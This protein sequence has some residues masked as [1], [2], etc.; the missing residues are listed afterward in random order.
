[1]KCPYCGKEMQSGFVPTD[2]TPAQWI[3]DGKK[4]SLLKTKYSN[5]CKKIVYEDTFFGI[6]AKADYCETCGIIL[7]KEDLR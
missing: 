4:Q 5:D 6:H 3:P 1:M 7:L 2:E